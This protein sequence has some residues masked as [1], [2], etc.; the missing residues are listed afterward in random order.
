MVDDPIPANNP[1]PPEGAQR[2]VGITWGMPE[3]AGRRIEI[4]GPGALLAVALAI[5]S[6]GVSIASLSAL[7]ATTST[8]VPSADSVASLSPDT[9]RLRAAAL[10]ATGAITSLP[11]A[12]ITGT[13][14]ATTTITATPTISA[15]ST[16]TPTLAVSPTI[17]STPATPTTEPSATTIP[18]SDTPSPSPTELPP[19]ETP[20]DTPTNTATRTPTG[21]R[22]ST[23]T[24]EPSSTPTDASPTEPPSATPTPRERS[25]VN[26]YL[27]IAHRL[28]AHAVPIFGVQVSELRFRDPALIDESANVGA[29]WYRTFFYWDEVEPVRT[30]PPTYDWR[31]YD[32]IIT[33]ASEQGLRI[34]AEISGNPTWAADV[35]GGPVHDLDTLAEFMAAAVE[36][37]DGDGVADAPGSPVVRHWE[38]YNEPDNRS[39]ALARQGRG[40]GWW[41]DRGDQY[42]LMLRRV[43]PVIKLTSPEARV[44]FGGVSW[45]SVPSWGDPFDPDF[46]HDVLAAGGGPYFDDFNIHYYPIFAPTW[47][48]WGPGVLGK[49]RAAREVLA[50]YGLEKPIMVTEAGTWS[51]AD[52]TYPP[53]SPRDQARY[54]P[55]LFS[56][57][58]AG[59]V[60][61]VV[62]YHLDDVE[63]TVDPLRGLVAGDLE[64]KESFSAYRLARDVLGGAVAVDLAPPAPV[65][66]EVYFFRRG[67]ERIAVAWSDGPAEVLAIPAESAVRI[68]FLGSRI[69]IRDSADGVADGVIHVPFGTDPIYV[70][71]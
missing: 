37:Y 20:T 38:M 29:E 34:I 9:A 2:R 60:T 67:D 63:G 12:T 43:Y 7:A 14:S 4:A 22:T 58:M 53:T 50:E 45:E 59:G 13:V 10:Y 18:P 51:E 41:G 61:A 49:T 46:V 71:Y 6:L 3:L 21:T 54:V 19:T 65:S 30:S 64:R 42:A 56:R 8:R 27:P 26:I 5:V 66:G 55:Q 44:V 68:H 70:V 62:W 23:A 33:R 24:L 17:A 39:L 35:P 31:H 15:T 32:P 11:T 52:E 47:A 69:T 25:G 57:A 40:W 28:E 16:A 48:R 36:R 1:R